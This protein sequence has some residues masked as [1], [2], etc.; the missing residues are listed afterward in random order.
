MMGSKL[1]R[2]LAGGQPIALLYW[3]AIP[4]LTLYR[5]CGF[6]SQSDSTIVHLASL[7]QLSNTD[8]HSGVGAYFTVNGQNKALIG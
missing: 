6:V 5:I 1:N 8:C 4:Q 2:T 3:P 7:R